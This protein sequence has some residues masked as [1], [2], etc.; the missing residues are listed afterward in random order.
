MAPPLLCGKD[1]KTN[2]RGGGKVH[3]SSS[4]AAGVGEVVRIPFHDMEG[5]YP[6]DTLLIVAGVPVDGMRSDLSPGHIPGGGRLP[7]KT[8]HKKLDQGKFLTS[9]RTWWITSLL[10]PHLQEGAAAWT[11]LSVRKRQSL[12]REGKAVIALLKTQLRLLSSNKL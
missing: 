4:A 2:T 1:T 3:Q 9:M 6:I 11:C 5:R 7:S 10:L 12:G 8:K